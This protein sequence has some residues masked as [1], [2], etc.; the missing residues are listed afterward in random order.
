M[1]K[2]VDQNDRLPRLKE[3]KIFLPLNYVSTYGI[4]RNIPKYITLDEIKDNI[5]SKISITN[6]ERL[7]YWNKDT[8]EALPG[9]S[10]KINFRSNTR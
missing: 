8:K 5:D 10:I 6:L 3:Y 2:Q 1:C 9:T 4:V 7:N